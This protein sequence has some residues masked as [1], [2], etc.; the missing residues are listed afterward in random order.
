MNSEL[1][2]ALETCGNDTASHNILLSNGT[3]SID[4]NA[5]IACLMLDAASETLAMIIKCR[6][7][8]A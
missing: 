6:A 5:K 3:K 4:R 8:I 1:L 7:R 2:E